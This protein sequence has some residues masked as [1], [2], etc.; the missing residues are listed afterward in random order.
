MVASVLAQDP[1]RCIWDDFGGGLAEAAPRLQQALQT[2]F[3]ASLLT[4]TR[5]QGTQQIALLLSGLSAGFY[6]ATKETNISG[7][8][9]K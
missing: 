1:L 5:K 8:L 2:I 7:N 4:V 9:V 3:P 6:K